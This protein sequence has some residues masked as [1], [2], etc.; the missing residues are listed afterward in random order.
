[1]PEPNTSKLKSHPWNRQA[2]RVKSTAAQLAELRAAHTDHAAANSAAITALREAIAD[3]ARSIE[4]LSQ[5]LARLYSDL[6]QVQNQ[7]HATPPTKP[8]RPQGRLL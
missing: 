2:A 7:L 1:M 3:Q 5:D 4:H 8:P 6:D